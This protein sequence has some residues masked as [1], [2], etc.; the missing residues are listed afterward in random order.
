MDELYLIRIMQ[1]FLEKSRSGNVKS[2]Q[3]MVKITIW[4]ASGM[5]KESLPEASIE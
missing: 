2:M 5:G 1:L 4:S 3:K